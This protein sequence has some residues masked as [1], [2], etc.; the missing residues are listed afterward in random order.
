M[1]Q[2]YLI[3]ANSKKGQLIF[4]V[5]KGVDLLILGCGAFITLIL[6]FLLPQGTLLTTFLKLMPLGLAIILVFP[7][8]FYHNTRVFLQELLIYI[9]SQKRY[10]WKGW[11]CSYVEDEQQ[12]K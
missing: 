6:V 1:R 12:H 7:I 10:H 4:N 11:C 9:T 5:F 3:P 8:A 2:Q